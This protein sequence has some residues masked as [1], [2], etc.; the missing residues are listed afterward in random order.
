MVNDKIG[1]GVP[2]IKYWKAAGRAEVLRFFSL[3]SLSLF[4]SFL[5]LKK[6]KK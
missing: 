3:F 5:S 2:V 1:G 6:K 4:L